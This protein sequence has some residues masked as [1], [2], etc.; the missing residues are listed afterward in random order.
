MGVAL[1]PSEGHSRA[2]LGEVS[3]DMTSL[4]PIKERDAPCAVETAEA[5]ISIWRTWW[6]Q[7][8]GLRDVL[9]LAMPL[10]VSTLSNTLMIF[11]DR[12][13]LF[14]YSEEAVAASL[15]AGMFAFLVTCLPWGIAIYVN[16]F[17]AQYYGAERHERIGLVV[18]QGVYVG[19]ISIPLV[20]ATMPLAPWFFDAAGHHDLVAELET[21]YYQVMCWG[22]GA[23]IISAAL[24]SFF[25][26]RGNTRTV[27]VVDSIAAALNIALDY[28]WI[29]GHWGFPE[30]GVAG[31]A[32][33]TVLA[34]W[35]KT[36]IYF[37]LFLNRKHREQYATDTGCRLDLPLLRRLLRYG[38][39]NGMQFVLELGGFTAFLL[40][41]G[42]L[43]TAEMTAT[44]LAF[45]VNSLAF[46]PVWGIGMAAATIVGQHM[47]EGRSDLAARGT[48]WA[49]LVASAY[50]L[51]ISALYVLG[52]DLVL[53]A[54]WKMAKQED[55]TELRELT[56]FLLRFVA[57]Y[58]WFDAMCL[59]FSN[60]IK[61][62]GDVRFVLVTTLVMG[63]VLAGL[64]WLFIET[65]KLGL[66]WSWIM[67]TAWVA[68]LGLIYTLR[69]LQ[70][71]WRHMSV[72]E[73]PALV[74]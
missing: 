73:E 51:S 4:P 37:A 5:P 47:G 24:A 61:G 54:H 68:V 32:W 25:T 26:G 15:P 35:I 71:R 52:P 64:S 10:V 20:L 38:T 40:L 29:F 28:A 9:T 14:G 50:T 43:G 53:W 19:L 39:P 65:W 41:V 3:F 21:V 30:W 59:I 60:A 6:T 62:A 74:D 33:A 45:N 13:M 22:A 46:M 34:L 18:W 48:L 72:I 17:V 57:A 67:I 56:I 66:V 63:C 58:G 31:A 1:S 27:M 8:A 42:R 16:T 44:N 36:A 55:L 11:I 23:T 7:P 12:V 2:W 49:F 69:F 70:G